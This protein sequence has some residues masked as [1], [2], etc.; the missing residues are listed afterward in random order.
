MY[1]YFNFNFNLGGVSAQVLVVTLHCD[2]D[3][4]IPTLSSYQAMPGPL[5][6]GCHSPI[7]R[8]LCRCVLVFLCGQPTKKYHVQT[9]VPATNL[10][11]SMQQGKHSM[12]ENSAIA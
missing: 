10:P 11:P 3:M 1:I 6:A 2:S 4:R 5:H 7:V 12:S 8:G 9:D